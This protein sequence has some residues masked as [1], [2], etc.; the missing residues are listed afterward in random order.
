[1][2]EISFA[3]AD[4]YQRRGIGTHL[5]LFLMSL[6]KEQGIKGFEATVITGNIGMI[7]VFRKS[8]CVLHSEYNSG[9]YSLYFK[10]DEKISE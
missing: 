9:M 10:F 1:M 3:V 4:D 2:A 6:A 8:G 5:L 7:N